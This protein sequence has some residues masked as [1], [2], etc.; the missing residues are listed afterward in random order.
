MLQKSSGRRAY[1]HRRKRGSTWKTGRR[2]VPRGKRGLQCPS[3]LPSPSSP[4]TYLHLKSVPNTRGRTQKQ[5]QPP[6]STAGRKENQIKQ[7]VV[8]YSTRGAGVISRIK[9]PKLRPAAQSKVQLNCPNWITTAP[10][11]P[12]QVA[13]QIAGCSRWGGGCRAPGLIR[14][15]L[16]RRRDW[17]EMVPAQWVP[18]SPAAHPRIL[19]LLSPWALSPA[20]ALASSAQGAKRISHHS[21]HQAP[22]PPQR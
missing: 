8:G 18:Q 3:T 16:G 20:K 13:Q 19:V 1:L 15:L 9:A 11:S 4:Y 10:G 17:K 6:S 22:D 2:E 14:R 7:M 12:C 5:P 21:S